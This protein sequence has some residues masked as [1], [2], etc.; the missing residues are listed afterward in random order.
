MSR[1]TVLLT[2][3]AGEVPARAT[4]VVVDVLRASTTLTV[5]RGSGAREVLAAATPE[6]AFARARS[7]PGAL[8]CGERDGRRIPGFDLGNSPFEYRPET[9][10]GR[11]LVCA[12]T[13][14]SLALRRAAAARRRLLGAFVNANA[15]ARAVA[16]EP[17][18][19]I[20]C[21]GKLGRFCIEDAAFAGWLA[22]R[23][24]AGGARLEGAAARFART[25]AP[26][27]AAAVRA[28]LQ[29]A[30]QGRHLRSLGPEYA[31]DLEFCA[32]L[33]RIGEAYEV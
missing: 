30:A 32:D 33:D 13:N 3:A 24:A 25:L 14:G 2:P 1:V 20:I 15:V 10:G 19:A 4:A 23:L 21:S 17:E 12:S 29:G 9:V 27:D 5:A 6:E 7:H 26:P 11:T 28:L 31:A 18:V 16:D 8:L 22:A